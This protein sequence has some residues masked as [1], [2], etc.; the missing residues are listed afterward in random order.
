[1]ETGT[2]YRGRIRCDC[3]RIEI[4]I[5]NKRATPEYGVAQKNIRVL[6][7]RFLYAKY[8]RVSTLAIDWHSC[9]E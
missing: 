2:A 1:M 9:K 7:I 4:K 8:R 5:S 6:M 3:R